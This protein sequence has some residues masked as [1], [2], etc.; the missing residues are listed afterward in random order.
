AARAREL[1]CR[2]QPA[3]EGRVVEV[4]EATAAVLLTEP[5]AAEEVEPV[6]GVK[7]E[8]P[9]G[10]GKVIRFVAEERELAEEPV[11]RE[12]FDLDVD[13]EWL[14]IVGDDLRLLRPWWET[15]WVEHRGR[16]WVAREP[17]RAPQVR[18]QGIE[19]KVPGTGDGG[20]E[21]V[22]GGRAAAENGDREPLLLREERPSIDGVVDRA[23]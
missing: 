22:A 19:V 11:E 3:V 8:D 2:L 7:A 13:S 17:F 16:R 15:G 10:D 1:L 12:L 20:S 18:R 21:V 4:G 6:C 23:S 5:P 9:S 14:E